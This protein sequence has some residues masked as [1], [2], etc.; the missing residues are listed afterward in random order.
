MGRSLIDGDEL[1]GSFFGQAFGESWSPKAVPYL[2]AVGLGQ[3]L[4]DAGA[5]SPVGSSAWEAQCRHRG[6][7]RLGLSPHRA[8]CS[9]SSVRPVHGRRLMNKGLASGAAG[10]GEGIKS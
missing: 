10:G 5:E 3:Y 7:V 6:L 4:H 1:L 2:P 9:G 8:A